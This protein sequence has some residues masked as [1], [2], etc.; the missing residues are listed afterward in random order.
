MQPVTSA[1]IIDDNDQSYDVEFYIHEN[2]Q[3]DVIA[4]QLPS[5]ARFQLLK[6]LIDHKNITIV[7]RVMNWVQKQDQSVKMSSFGSSQVNLIVD[8]KYYILV[9]DSEQ[10]D[11]Q[12]LERKINYDS[13]QLT[14]KIDMLTRV[15]TM[16]TAQ[17]EK[18]EQTVAQQRSDLDSKNIEIQELRIQI[19]HKL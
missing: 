15:A 2:S 4:Y 16:L 7:D 6:P 8:G 1:I 14:S 9:R 5:H 18:L 17:I 13:K 3:V 10:T 11:I 19:L 12:R